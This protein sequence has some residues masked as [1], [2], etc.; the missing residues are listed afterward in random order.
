MPTWVAA[1]YAIVKELGGV[2]M[3]K[4]LLESLIKRKG[5]TSEE[6][7]RFEANHADYLKRIADRGGQ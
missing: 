4:D 6:V 3:A 1:V 5:Y 2:D 7:A